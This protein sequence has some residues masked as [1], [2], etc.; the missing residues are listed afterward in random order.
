MSDKIQASFIRPSQTNAADPYLPIHALKN[1]LSLN[2][3]TC[4]LH[5]KFNNIT[6]DELQQKFKQIVGTDGIGSR[7]RILGILFSIELF[8]TIDSF[9]E[10]SIGMQP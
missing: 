5:E 2:A 8:H 10:K 1:I 4:L 3:M 7:K 9:V 6:D